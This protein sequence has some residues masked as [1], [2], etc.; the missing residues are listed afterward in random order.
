MFCMTRAVPA[1]E[2]A[3]DSRKQKLYRLN[4]PLGK[5]LHHPRGDLE[6]RR[7]ATSFPGTSLPESAGKKRDP[8]NEAGSCV[9]D[10]AA[11]SNYMYK[12][13]SPLEDIASL[14]C[15]LEM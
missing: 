15:V 12:I 5:L 7:C 9:D 3:C 4:R 14:S 11:F 10:R 13:T 2:I 8:G 1:P 6:R